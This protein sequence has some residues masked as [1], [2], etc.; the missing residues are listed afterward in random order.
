MFLQDLQYF[1]HILETPNI[2]LATSSLFSQGKKNTPISRGCHPCR[3]WQ[4]AA[5]PLLWTRP[6]ASPVKMQG[7]T[8]REPGDVWSVWRFGTSN[9][10]FPSQ[11]SASFLG[12]GWQFLKSLV[13][14]PEFDEN[15]NKI[16]L[17]I[18]TQSFIEKN[19]LQTN[20]TKSTKKTQKIVQVLSSKMA[21][22]TAA[23]PTNPKQRCN[24]GHWLQSARVLRGQT[25]P[26][27]SRHPGSLM[28]GNLKIS[29]FV[30]KKDLVFYGQV[31]DISL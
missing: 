21:C 28:D 7:P 4:R 30:R 11:N 2:S 9:G 3:D 5:D 15:S 23:P 8:E 20:T 6:S 22:C 10:Q 19:Q 18:P 13:K 25:G 17:Q 16:S 26:N 29:F 14:C 12:I 1:F 27:S 31:V 24:L